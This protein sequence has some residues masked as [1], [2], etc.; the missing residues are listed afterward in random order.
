MYL[1]KIIIVSILFEGLIMKLQSILI[2]C[3][4]LLFPHFVQAEE[5]I[6]AVQ[7]H[8]NK[9]LDVLRDKSIKEESSASIRKEKIRNISNDMFDYAELSK[10]TM[11]QNWKKLSDAEQAEFVKLYKQI[12]ENAYINKLLAY[13]DEQVVFT[14]EKK[15]TEINAEVYTKVIT[16]T[17]EIP[18][19]YRLVLKDNGWKVYDISI[20]G[21]S[22]VSN[23]RTQFKEILMNKSSVEFLD[24][25][26]KK[27]STI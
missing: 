2:I 24:I 4:I 6:N 23:Y 20:E 9:V 14:K 15:L 21:V 11:G 8:I 22:L 16:K 5:P 10:R 12:L 1:K 26:R 27:V 25:L 13:K 3:I 17:V 18:I 7:V 19:D